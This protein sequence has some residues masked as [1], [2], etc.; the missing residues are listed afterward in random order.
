MQIAGKTGGFSGCCSEFL[1]RADHCVDVFLT[2]PGY[3]AAVLFFAVLH[4]CSRAVPSRLHGL[5]E[6]GHIHSLKWRG[7][8]CHSAVFRS[9]RSASVRQGGHSFRSPGLGGAVAHIDGVCDWGD[10]RRTRRNPSTFDWP[11]S[12]I[13]VD[14]GNV[15]RSSP[16]LSLHRLVPI[17][18]LSRLLQCKGR[19]TRN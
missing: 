3:V 9:Q 13:N 2:A 15:G 8:S 12:H 16:L 4:A 17:L 14:V 10:D 11:R 1:V 5:G 6:S 19:S 7:S 18:P